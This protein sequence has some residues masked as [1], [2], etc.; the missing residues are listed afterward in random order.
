M[1]PSFQCKALP[2]MYRHGAIT[3]EEYLAIKQSFYIDVDALAND[4]LIGL[5]SLRT[6]S[7]HQ[8]NL[9]LELGESAIYG[10]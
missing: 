10:Q 8:A 4:T 2:D 7:N 5:L 1:S 3:W 9:M 6:L